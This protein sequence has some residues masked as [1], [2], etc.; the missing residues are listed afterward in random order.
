M[1]VGAKVTLA[2]GST[3]PLMSRG[4]WERQRGG[5]TI[6]I[7]KELTIFVCAFPPERNQQT[8]EVRIE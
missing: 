5:E 1:T 6:A 8:I 3:R 4:D 7:V 2:G